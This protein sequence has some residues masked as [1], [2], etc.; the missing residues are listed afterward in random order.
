MLWSDVS[1]D[2]N[3]SKTFAIKKRINTELFTD[4][5]AALYIADGRI[6]DENCS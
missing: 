4:R 6:K 5:M 1:R 3:P 2:A